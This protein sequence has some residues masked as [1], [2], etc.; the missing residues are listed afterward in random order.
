M[1]SMQTNIKFTSNRA[2]GIIYVYICQYHISTN[3]LILNYK[4]KKSLMIGLGLIAIHWFYCGLSKWG[5]H[6]V[7][8][9]GYCYFSVLPKV[10]QTETIQFKL[11]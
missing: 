4:E 8:L 7:L 5:G 10:L 11:T 3:K 9:L 1:K 6:Q 2:V